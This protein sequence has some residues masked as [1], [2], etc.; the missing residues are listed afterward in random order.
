[1]GNDAGTGSDFIHSNSFYMDASTDLTAYALDTV[2]PSDVF[3]D[4]GFR[5]A[6]KQLDDNDVPMDQRFLVV[7]P[8]VMQT[9]RGITRYNSADFVSGQPTVNGQV[10]TL[11]GIDIYVS[12]NC[13]VIETAAANSNSTSDT[14]AGILGHRDAMVFAE[15]MGVRT[16]TQYKQEYLGDLFT[17]D[18][19]YGVKVL[20]PESALVLAFP[21]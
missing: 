10:G 18:T 14:K 21:A 7:P 20:R 19:L 8:S 13:P 17:A 5:A 1:L 6:I 15:Q 2:T 16:Q 9:I 12:T 3:S 4:D 11:Y